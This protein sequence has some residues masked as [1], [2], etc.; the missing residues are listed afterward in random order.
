MTWTSVP[1][2]TSSLWTTVAVSGREQYDQQ[3]ITYDSPIT[4]YD[5]VNPMQW[6]S[7]PKPISSLWTKV[8]KPI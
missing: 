2:P 5:G 7:V 8:A 1:K 6:S 3:D 4:F